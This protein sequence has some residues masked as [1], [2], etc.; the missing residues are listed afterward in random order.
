MKT[1]VVTETVQYRFNMPDDWV[2]P[3]D[4][5]DLDLLRNP[6]A[7]TR[8]QKLEDWYCGIQNPMGRA[9]HYDCLNRECHVETT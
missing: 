8:E 5:P 1:I 4:D 7:Q 3:E 2:P 9:A 6:N